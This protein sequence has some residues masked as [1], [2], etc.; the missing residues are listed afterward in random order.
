MS[1]D[2]T[3]SSTTTMINIHD[4]SPVGTQREPIQ[5]R[6]RHVDRTSNQSL[7]IGIPKEVATLANITKGTAFN[8]YVEFSTPRKI[9]LEKVDR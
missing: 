5:R 2:N 9:I 8:I 7:I 1:N 3:T 4:M 6:C